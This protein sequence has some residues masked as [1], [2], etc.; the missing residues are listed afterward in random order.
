MS[1]DLETLIYKYA[2]Q[3]AVRYNGKAS[4]GA[5]TS[6]VFAERPDLRPKARE[7]VELV[8]KVVSKVNSMTLED[9]MRE[10][11]E[12]FP[13]MLE[14]KKVEQRKGLPPLPNPEKV[15]VR[16]APNPDGPLHLGNARAAVI[17]D[18]YA[19]MYKGKFILRFDDT[20]P[21]VKV[22]IAEAY[23]WIREDL[24]WLGVV[25]HEE[26]RA[27]ARLKIYYDYARKLI[28][29]GGAYVDTC[30][31]EEFREH[32]ASKKPCPNRLESPEENLE[33]FDKMMSSPLDFSPFGG[34]KPV[35]RIKTDLNSPDPSMVDWVI[36][37]IIETPN[38]PLVKDMYVWPTYN[39]ASAIDDYLLGTTHIFRGKEHEQ[40][41]QK[42]KWVYSYF[43]WKY[44]YVQSFGRLK[45]E[46]FMMS[47]SKI[48]LMLERGSE[49]D[50]PRLPTLAGL[51]RRGILPETIR[52]VLIE[53]GIKPNDATISFA[54]LAA[55]NRKFLDPIAKRLMF[56]HNYQEFRLDLSML[57]VYR[58]TAKLPY[59]PGKEQYREIEVR[60]GD[61]IALNLDDAALRRLR[62]MELCNAEVRGNE[63]L[64]V[65]RSLDEAKKEGLQIVQWVKKNESVR[66][67]VY[68]VVGSEDFQVLEGIGENEFKKLKTDEIVQLV[69][70]GF[71]RVDYVSTEGVDMVFSHD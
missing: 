8:K 9:Q 7:I 48:K 39:F 52:E 21:K 55:V 20:D 68:K 63:L 40:N 11:K 13:E 59:V 46:G 2:L 34:R 14:E 30:T 67:K 43:N 24:K 6:K 5:V 12:K 4:E 18:E 51:R 45:L 71:A 36:L 38:H 32:R 50:D 64:C 61:I 16:F 66:V 15:V 54:N 25:V 44:P 57:G 29:I 35:V 42:Q 28:E 53:I 10:L 33:M 1:E 3:N 70:L 23:D 47:K 49:R 62:L 26:V 22:P 31:E 69:R 41:T 17:N 56:V 37:R 19:K 65:S 60:H 27:S 58:L